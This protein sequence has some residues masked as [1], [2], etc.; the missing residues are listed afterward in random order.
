MTTMT[1]PKQDVKLSIYLSPDS[2]ENIAELAARSGV[3]G[4]SLAKYFRLLADYAIDED[5]IFPATYTP[6][7]RSDRQED[8]NDA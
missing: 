5:L 6:E 4:V 3:E 1:L 7:S 2:K 8:Q